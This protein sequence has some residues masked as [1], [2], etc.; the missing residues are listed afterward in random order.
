MRCIAH[1]KV[2]IYMTLTF[3]WYN[4]LCDQLHTRPLY[5]PKVTFD[6]QCSDSR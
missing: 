2:R 1:K 5:P 4:S 3:L 6:G